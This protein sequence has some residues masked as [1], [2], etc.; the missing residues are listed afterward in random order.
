VID[1]NNANHN[2]VYLA[3]SKAWGLPDTTIG[4]PKWNTNLLPPLG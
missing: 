2:E 3:I 4:D 1:C